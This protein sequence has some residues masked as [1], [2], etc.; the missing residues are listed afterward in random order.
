MARCKVV[1][2][3]LFANDLIRI[4]DLTEEAI[5]RSI[6][7]GAKIMADAVRA[8]LDAIPTDNAFGTE[9]NK[10]SGIT[11]AQKAGLSASLG[12]AKMRKSNGSYEVKI[13]FDGYN[14]LKTRKYPS[15]QPNALIAR[16][17]ESGTSFRRKIPF[18]SRAFSKANASSNEA[19]ATTFESYMK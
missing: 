8:E 7:E 4:D 11:S 3:E 1:G 19:M 12:I 9:D 5:G 14:T 18:I 2:I 13:G 10:A 16:S 6:F 15:G 17:L